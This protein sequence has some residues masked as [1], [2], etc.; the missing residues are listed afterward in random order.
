MK[1]TPSAHYHEEV[2]RLEQKG[3]STIESFK[4]KYL[5][6]VSKDLELNFR[7]N[8]ISAVGS[9]SVMVNQKNREM[10]KQVLLSLF[11]AI[12]SFKNE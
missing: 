2:L 6:D 9:Q 5:N 10:Q 1:P 11:T 3:S 7:E 4:L 8:R 12:D